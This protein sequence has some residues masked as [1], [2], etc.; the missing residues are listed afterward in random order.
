YTSSPLAISEPILSHGATTISHGS[1]YSEPIL[2]HGAATIS[3]GPIDIAAPA[4]SFSEALPASLPSA[5]PCA[6]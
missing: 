1:S 2:S 5:C 3:H 4:T 6:Y